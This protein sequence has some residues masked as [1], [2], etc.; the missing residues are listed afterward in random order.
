MEYGIMRVEKRHRNAVHG[1]Q[2]EANRSKS[3][4]NKGRDFIR[5]DIDWD[6][7]SNNIHLVRSDDWEQAITD[8]I[9]A[10]DAKERKDSVVMLDALYTASADFFAN[11]NNEQI[12]QYFEDCLYFHVLTYC[13]GDRSRLINAVIHLD[14][15]T[16]HLQVAS[17]PIV[18]IDGKK[19]LNA[20]RLMGNRAD[21][22]KR[23]DEFY[24]MVSRSWN[25]ERGEKLET[26]R[27]HLDVLDYKI[28]TREELVKA[29]FERFI[30]DELAIYCHEH[31]IDDIKG[32]KEQIIEGYHDIYEDEE[33]EP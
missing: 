28:K 10:N 13:E 9:Q 16:P 15:S 5:S 12:Q 29:E 21:Y 3:E 24:D 1:L 26:K 30:N 2:L 4:H 8:C 20:K 32:F 7:T 14:E 33:P 23:Q 31:N 18:D 22:I 25:L 27:K 17:V 19:R 11:K 6:M